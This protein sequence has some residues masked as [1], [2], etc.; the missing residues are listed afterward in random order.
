MP[1]KTFQVKRKLLLP[2]FTSGKLQEN[3]AEKELEKAKTIWKTR[4]K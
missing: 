3:E 2:G 4:A 1:G